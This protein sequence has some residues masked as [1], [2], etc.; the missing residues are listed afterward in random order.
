MLGVR[1]LKKIRGLLLVFALVIGICFGV[2]VN[3]NE[4]NG[5]ATE[6]ITETTTETETGTEIETETQTTEPEAEEGIVVREPFTFK[7]NED[8]TG[9]IL[10]GYNS[11]EGD[12]VVDIPPYCVGAFPLLPVVEIDT[13]AFSDVNVVSITIPR[14]V[15]KMTGDGFH[16]KTKTKVYI[17]SLY[18]WCEI[19]FYSNTSNP[20]YTLLG[21]GSELY[22]NDTLVKD[23]VIPDGIT[24]IKSHA[25]TNC[26]NIKTVTIPKSV[27]KIGVNAF[28]SNQNLQHIYYV[29]TENEVAEIE[30]SNSAFSKECAPLIHY[31]CKEHTIT[32]TSTTSF[33]VDTVQ[34]ECSCGYSWLESQVQNEHR[35]VGDYCENCGKCVWGYNLLDDGTILVNDCFDAKKRQNIIIPHEVDGYTVTAIN[36]INILA[37]AKTIVVPDTV[38]SVSGII[39]NVLTINNN[40]PLEKIIIPESVTEFIGI[41]VQKEISVYGVP[42]SKAEEFAVQQE[43]EFVDIS[44]IYSI[45]SKTTEV[46]DGMLIVDEVKETEIANLLKPSEDYTVSVV[47][48]QYNIYSTG[49]KVQIKDKDGAVLKEH[50]LVVKGDL[51]GDGVCDGLDCM[52]VE[53]ARTKCTNLSGSVFLAGNLTDDSEITIDD[54][55]AVVNKAIS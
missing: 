32:Y 18:S 55:N 53:L 24:E 1:V 33:C 7:L 17:S 13:D 22:L 35:Y 6:E 27:K 15:K 48:T 40:S 30:V 4:D 50:I 20:L 2:P 23:L 43:L 38:V 25:F 16:Y 47:P 9:Y 44:T 21:S 45:D 41:K 51:N 12:T 11:T 36:F 42:G 52:L 8:G 46:T 39:L 37:N 26:D 10:I 31:N 14:T 5:E 3:A 34:A 54:F 49:T 28:G 29:A 19:D